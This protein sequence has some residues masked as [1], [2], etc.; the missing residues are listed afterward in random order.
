MD[1][2]TMMERK[3]TRFSDHHY[4]GQVV[5]QTIIKKIKKH[6]VACETREHTHHYL[7]K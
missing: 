6:N 2:W 5:K 7:Y 4:F 1:M 3:K